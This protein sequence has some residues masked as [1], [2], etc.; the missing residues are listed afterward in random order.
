VNEGHL[1]STQ[2]LVERC[3]AD[4]SIRTRN[5]MN[6]LHSAIAS[7]SLSVV[8]YVYSKTKNTIHVGTTATGATVL[9][10]ATGMTT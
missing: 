6:L 7:G 2:Y 10:I 9:H 3:K 4:K 5:G 1:A 8:K